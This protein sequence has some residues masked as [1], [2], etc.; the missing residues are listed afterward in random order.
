M[1]ENIGDDIS[2]RT[3]RYWQNN[4]AHYSIL[5]RPIHNLL[6]AKRDNTINTTKSGNPDTLQ[7]SRTALLHFF[8]LVNLYKWIDDGFPSNYFNLFE[9]T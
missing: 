3:R 2:A 9:C 5:A 7:Q 6:H 8:L 1:V 4:A